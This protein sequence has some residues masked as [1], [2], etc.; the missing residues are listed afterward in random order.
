MMLLLS[1]LS[2]CHW[3]TAQNISVNVD[4]VTYQCSGSTSPSSSSCDSAVKSLKNDL[5]LCASSYSVDWC[6][7]NNF[8]LFKQHNPNC[9]YQGRSICIAQCKTHY[10]L[11]WCMQTACQ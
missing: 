10:S 9:F 5:D 3:A 1:L 11:D 8:P 4:G 6:L 7:L 2:V